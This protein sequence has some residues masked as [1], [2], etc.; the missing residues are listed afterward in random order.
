LTLPAGPATPALLQLA[1]YWLRPLPLLERCHRRYGD[2][3]TLRLGF[4]GTTVVLAA[5]ADI[6][7]VYTA[8]PG[9]L[10][11]GAANTLLEPLMGRNSLILLDGAAYNRQ[12][13]LL[14]PPLGAERMALYTDAVKDATDAV[15]DGWRDGEPLSLL[16]AAEAVTLDVILRTVFG[17]TSHPSLGEALRRLLRTSSSYA[18][19]FF[20]GDHG[21][22]SPGGWLRGRVRAADQL[23]YHEI[24]R[25]RRS[26][27]RGVDVLS[28]LIDAADD[29]GAPLTNEEIRDELVT[30]LTGGYETTA[31]TIAWTAS[32][33]IDHPEVEARVRTEL[34][35]SPDG[36]G[37]LEAVIRESL[38]LRPIFNLS[39]RQLA[40]PFEIAGHVLPAG[41]IVAPCMY[42]AQRRPELWPEPERFRPERFLDGR[43]EPPAWFPFGGGHRRCIG[44]ALAMH[45]TR[46]FLATLVSRTRLERV[47]PPVRPVRKNIILVP[48]GGA[49]IRLRGAPRPRRARR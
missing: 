33:L 28:L 24:A 34:E 35:E 20:P 9:V 39:I 16:E 14:A 26:G 30:L 25:R 5:P 29:E 38:R 13:K 2:V 10:L 15:I 46:T 12:R 47:G 32:L 36:G 23:I 27:E 40:E 31:A 4:L 6:R 48:S 42:L 41:V 8:P 43:P 44:M 18:V 22:L 7:R 3:F 21:A 45:E 17:V 19:L 49:R 37:Y 11:G 1:E